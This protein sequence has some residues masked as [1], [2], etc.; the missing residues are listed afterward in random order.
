MTCSATE[1]DYQP[2][3]QEGKLFENSN[4]PLDALRQRIDPEQTTTYCYVV[5][6]VKNEGGRLVQRESAPNFQGGLITLCTCKHRMRTSRSPCDWEGTWIAGFTGVGAAGGRNA[7][8]YLT[9]VANA[10]E[11]HYD[12]WYSQGTPET[13]KQAKSARSSKCGDLFQPLKRLSDP[14]DPRDY[15]QPCDDHCHCG[16]D[17]HR[18]VNYTGYSERRAALLVGDPA[19]SFLWSRPT[20]FFPIGIGRSNPKTGLSDLLSQLE[21]G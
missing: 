3:P 9:R 16:D 17:W 21:E 1:R 5:D 6:T 10:F 14:F 13:A 4:L 2:F 19:Y 8:V 18:D 20:I 11:S 12:L 15:H 7:L